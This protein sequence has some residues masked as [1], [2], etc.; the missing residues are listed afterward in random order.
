MA[1]IVCQIDVP[2]IA[3]L[4]GANELQ[5]HVH[6][7]SGNSG[8]ICTDRSAP[9]RYVCAAIEDLL[10]IAADS[11]QWLVGDQEIE[12]R[13]AVSLADVGLQKGDSML[14]VH[15]GFR[16]LARLADTFELELTSVRQRFRTGYSS[17]FTILYK[18]SGCISEGWLAFQPWRKNDHDVYLFDT[19]EN[20]MHVEESHWMCGSSFSTRS[21]Q[22][23]DYLGDLCRAWRSDGHGLHGEDDR[24]WLSKEDTDCGMHRMSSESETEDKDGGQTHPNHAAL[25][26]WFLTPDEDC[27][28]VAVDIPLPNLKERVI[29]MLIDRTGAPIR[30]AVKGCGRGQ[31]HQDIEE[32]E[33]KLSAPASLTKPVKPEK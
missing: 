2:G 24:F 19:T 21:L 30:A 8:T 6:A 5:L 26:G 31:M 33:V 3:E 20:I 1:D 4:S 32:F 16:P 22:G 13:K 17:A 9:P 27:I 14:I 28:E 7:L 11:Q 12:F 10:G 29:R 23:E 15:T 18:I 25:P